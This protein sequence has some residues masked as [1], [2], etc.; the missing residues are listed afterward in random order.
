M[1][2]ILTKKQNKEHN[3]SLNEQHAQWN[4]FKDQNITEST[5]FDFAVNFKYT[6]NIQNVILTTLSKTKKEL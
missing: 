2:E 4:T 3:D 6:V 1:W 5:L